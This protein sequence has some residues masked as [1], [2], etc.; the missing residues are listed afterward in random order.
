MPESVAMRITGHK[1]RAIFDRYNIV[2]EEDVVE[3]MRKLEATKPTPRNLAS[4]SE[5]L[6]R[7]GKRK[8]LTSS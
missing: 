8:L 2:D 5:S 6:V 1:T 4:R 7:V 3:A